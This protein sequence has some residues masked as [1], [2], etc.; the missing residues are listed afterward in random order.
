MTLAFLP[1]AETNTPEV[2]TLVE[3]VPSI[4]GYR[5][6]S[7][8]ITAGFPALAAPPQGAALRRRL[9]LQ[10]RPVRPLVF[11]VRFPSLPS[12]LWLLLSRSGRGVGLFGYP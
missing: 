10:P 2:L 12:S 5:G 6:A 7:S 4:R 1:D 11:A 9:S 3:A 8:G